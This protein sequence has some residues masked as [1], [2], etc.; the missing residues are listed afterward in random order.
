MVSVDVKPKVSTVGWEV[1]ARGEG[2]ERVECAGVGGGGWRVGEKTQ[3]RSSPRKHLYR[4]ILYRIASFCIEP[5][6]IADLRELFC[7]ALHRTAQLYLH[8]TF[9]IKLNIPHKH[10]TAPAPSRPHPSPRP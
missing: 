9:T 4:T 8:Y 6:R 1:G 7:V 10:N 5:N 3:L 2:L